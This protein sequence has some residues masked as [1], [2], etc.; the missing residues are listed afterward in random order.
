MCIACA[1]DDCAYGT[2]KEGVWRTEEWKSG[3]RIGEITWATKG[4]AMITYRPAREEHDEFLAL[5]HR[6]T[7]T[8]YEG[9]LE[10]LEMSW[11]E[12]AGSRILRSGKIYRIGC[13]PDQHQSENPLRTHGI[14]GG[15][16]S[17]GSGFLRYAETAG[18]W[19]FLILTASA[20]FYALKNETSPDT[21]LVS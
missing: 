5:M 12:F 19:K 3:G 7:D 17:G 18:A 21:G 8:D 15:Q 13:R 11:E 2:R 9:V 6:Q 1:E 10:V 4:C 20:N 16:D 14:P